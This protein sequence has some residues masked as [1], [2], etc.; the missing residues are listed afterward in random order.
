MEN[1]QPG[2][3]TPVAQRHVKVDKNRELDPALTQHQSTMEDR[4]QALQNK[5]LIAIKTSDVLV[6]NQVFYYIDP[7]NFPLLSNRSLEML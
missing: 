7:L 4:A 5:Q 2:L 3:H 1:G 6:S